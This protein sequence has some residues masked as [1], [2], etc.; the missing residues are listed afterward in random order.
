MLLDRIDVSQSSGPGKLPGRLLQCLGK[1]ITYFLILF[2][3]SRD[4]NVS[5]G[6]INRQITCI[7]YSIGMHS[8][9]NFLCMNQLTK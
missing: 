5:V 4:H 8:C 1:E 9:N 6:K 3:P 7:K 2:I